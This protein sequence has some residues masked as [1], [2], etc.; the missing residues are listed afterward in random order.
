M[1][2]GPSDLA[3]LFFG[4]EFQMYQFEAVRTCVNATVRCND[5]AL[6]PGT[7]TGDSEPVV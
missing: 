3:K 7:L 4:A 2:P 5:Y 6:E 1:S